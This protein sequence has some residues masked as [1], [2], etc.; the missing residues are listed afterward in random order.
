M[1]FIK[2]SSTVL[3]V[4]FKFTFSHFSLRNSA[5]RLFSYIFN[6]QFWHQRQKTCFCGFWL[7]FA[8]KK[9]KTWFTDLREILPASVT[10]RNLASDYGQRL[11]TKKKWQLVSLTEFSLFRCNFNIINSII[12][13]CTCWPGCGTKFL[14]LQSSTW[15]CPL[16]GDLLLTERKKSMLLSKAS[17]R[18]TLQLRLNEVSVCKN[19]TI[20]VLWWLSGCKVHILLA[21]DTWTTENSMCFLATSP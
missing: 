15:N 18:K 14:D 2:G 5:L 9:Y 6:W 17:T 20:P 19:L 3:A 4:L 11:F 7:F 12:K 21:Q 8:D 10:D 1:I 16:T 13:K